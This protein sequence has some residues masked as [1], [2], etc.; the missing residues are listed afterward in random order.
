MV[1][2]DR[3]TKGGYIGGAKINAVGYYSVIIH[4]LDFVENPVCLVRRNVHTNVNIAFVRIVVVMHVSCVKN[5]V[6]EIV[7][8]RNV[9]RSVEKFVVYLHVKS[10]AI[11]ILNVVILALASVV[12]LAHLCVEFVIKRKLKNFSL[13]QKMKKMQGSFY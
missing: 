7:L 1:H 11:K 3:V 10:H 13:G 8:I 4:A 9:K 2:V 6:I 5:H 12:S